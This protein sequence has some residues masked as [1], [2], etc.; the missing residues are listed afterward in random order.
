MTDRSAVIT[1]IACVALGLVGCFVVLIE[2]PIRL[3][4]ESQ[5][6]PVTFRIDPNADDADTLCLLPRIGPGIAQRIVDDRTKQGP[7]ETPDDLARVPMVGEKTVEAL[8]PWI[9]SHD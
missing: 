3:G 6:R 1:L 8:R 7:F 4:D 5:T 2:R 9:V